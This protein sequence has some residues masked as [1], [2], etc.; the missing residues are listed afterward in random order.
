MKSFLILLPIAA[1]VL[2]R[3]SLETSAEDPVIGTD[4]VHG[5]YSSVGE[6]KLNKTNEFNARGLC[7]SLC[8][9]ADANVA[10][11]QGSKCYCG[12]KYPAASTLVDDSQCDE[13]CPGYS[14]EACGGTKFFTII[15]TGLSLAVDNSTDDSSSSKSSSVAG[16]SS[17]STSVASGATV[18]GTSAT[19]TP[20][21]SASNGTSST[22]SSV[23]TSSSI[24][25]STTAVSQN[26]A[27]S[28]LSLSGLNLAVLG[29]GAAFLM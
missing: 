7:A 29:L 22:G 14:A 19:A 1:T 18:S 5:C 23:G 13:P 20:T 28:Q 15:N 17:T 11:T 24:T 10:A 16:A 8:R 27:V 4:T 3:G 26:G 6:L 25:A 21:A 12:Q 9:D 2:A